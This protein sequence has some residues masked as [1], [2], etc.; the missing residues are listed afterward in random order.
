MVNLS[1]VYIIAV[2]VIVRYTKRASI[3]VASDGIVESS[4]YKVYSKSTLNNMQVVYI[5]I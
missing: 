1:N 4:N 5:Q 2:C 3:Y